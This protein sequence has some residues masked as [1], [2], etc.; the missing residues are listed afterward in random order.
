MVRVILV[1]MS[2]EYLTVKEALRELG[3]GRT[4]FY[5]LVRAGKITP[6]RNP[7][8]APKR[9]PVKIPRSQIEDLKQQ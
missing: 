4:K 7:L 8:Y 1:D 9:G 2:T 5:D 3:I 6:L